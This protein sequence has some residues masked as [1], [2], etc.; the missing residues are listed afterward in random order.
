MRCPQ[1]FEKK[2]NKSKNFMMISSFYKTNFPIF[3]TKNCKNKIF[4]IPNI[5]KNLSSFLLRLRLQFR[6]HRNFHSH[7]L[8]FNKGSFLGFRFL[9]FLIPMLLIQCA[10]SGFGTQGLLYENQRISMMETGITATKEGFSCSK[11]YLG[12]VAYGDASIEMAQRQGNIKEITSIE[13]E[14]YNFFGIYAKL[15]TVT[16]GN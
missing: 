2:K 4:I 1:K 16:R 6:L 3:W 14:T 11:S 13:L 5:H 10:S 12:L 7:I 9:Q 8:S 15:C